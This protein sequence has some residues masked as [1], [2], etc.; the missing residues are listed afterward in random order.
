[1]N[2]PF[3]PTDARRRAGKPRDDGVPDTDR[4]SG[5]MTWRT[6]AS[7]A[8]PRA[9]DTAYEQLL[10]QILDLRLPPGSTINEH[11]VAAQLGLSR[12][13]VHEAVARLAA[14]RLVTVLPRRASV[15]TDIRPQDALDMFD[16]REA[17]ECGVAHVAAR[18]ATDEDLAI[19]RTLIEAAERARKDTDHLRY[20]RQDHDI[21]YFL[22][23]MVP[24]ALL[25]D[26][27]DRLLMHNL[28]FWRSYWSGQPPRQVTMIS[29]ANLLA[30]L[31]AR[32]PE[33]AER[34]MRSHI[35]LSLEL[36][37]PIVQRD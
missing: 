2:R 22:V 33:R 31:E 23:H 24:N 5:R 4:G 19:L 12:M 15:V 1:M 36:V 14:D 18:R 10:S 9:S 21:H 34:A 6:S 32:D 37:P 8:K 17:I 29:H 13:P 30:A 16:A 27:A 26:A 20:L 11:A 25:Q 35:R 28:R 3:E 7:A